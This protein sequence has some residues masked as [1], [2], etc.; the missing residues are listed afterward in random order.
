MDWKTMLGYISGSVDKELLLRNGYLVAENRVLR[1][2][3]QGRLRLTDAK[4]PGATVLSPFVFL[5]TTGRTRSTSFSEVP[6]TGLPP[7][8]DRESYIIQGLRCSQAPGGGKAMNYAVLKDTIL[9]LKEQIIRTEAG[10]AQPSETDT[11]QGLI[12]PLFRALQWD[13]T[14]FDS[15]RSELRVPQFNEPVDYAFYSSRKKSARPSLLLEAK[16]LGSNIGHKNHVKQLTSY[17]GA[18][19]V[20]WGVLSD[21]NRYVLY[22]SL[23][24]KSFEEQKFLT[25]EVKTV[26][27][28]SGFTMDEFLKHLTSLLSRECLENEEIQQAYEE[29]MIHSRI[30]LALDSLLSTPFDT[31]CKAIQREFKEERVGLPEGIKISMKHIKAYV[32]SISDEAGRIPVDLEA[33]AIHTDGAVQENVLESG[34]RAKGGPVSAYGKRVT[35]GDLLKA[36]LVREGDQWRLSLKGEVVWGR[37]ERN[38]QL[39]VNNKGHG[40]PS[41]AFSAVTSKP[42]NGWYYWHYRDASGEWQRI[43]ALRSEYRRQVGKAKLALV[44]T[45]VDLNAETI[46]TDDAVRD[47]GPESGNPAKGRPV[48][49]HGKPVTVGDL[50]KA[51]LVREGDQW[52]LSL[53]GEVVWGRIKGNGQLEVNNECHN[54]PSTAFSAVTSKSGNG[55][56][57]WYCRD[58]GGEWQRIDTLRS[59]YRRQVEKAKLALV[60]NAKRDKA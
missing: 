56:H 38:G 6:T 49:A 47:N 18:T 12:N 2:Q 22:N 14:D 28:D 59:E 57:Y 52:R 16:R 46:H 36:G 30:K 7:S 19:G 13:F 8:L 20:Q 48:R 32:E 45:P 33:E 31:L 23:G 37:L 25:L 17:L 10:D 50:L 40:N 55:W 60:Y 39:K 54:S 41:K 44:R 15:I 53:K 24:G 51:G 34:N 29:H 26:D 3:I 42:G 35:I 9:K 21:G 1:N 27:T 11:R 43:D 4:R 58:A 5:D